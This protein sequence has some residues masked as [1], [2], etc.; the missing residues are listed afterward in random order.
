MTIY[1]LL[2]DIDTNARKIVPV[3]ESQGLPHSALRAVAI[4]D[5]VGD[6]RKML[7][8]LKETIGEPLKT[9]ERAA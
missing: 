8:S 1:E 3:L 4:V 5:R 7:A 9:E 6:V 2:Q